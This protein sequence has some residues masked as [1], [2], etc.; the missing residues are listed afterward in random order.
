[1]TQATKKR[2]SVLADVLGRLSTARVSC[3][4]HLVHTACA[5]GGGD[6]IRVEAGAGLEA[7]SLI[8]RGQVYSAVA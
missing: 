1:M 6:F 4:I 3:P 7:P 8:R 5:D 2:G